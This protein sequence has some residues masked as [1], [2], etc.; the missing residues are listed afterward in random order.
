[1]KIITNFNK[2][3]GY[4]T[5]VS[6]QFIRA[7]GNDIDK[8][9][10]L[11]IIYLDRKRSFEDVV[12]FSLYDLVLS[13]GYKINRTN[14]GAVTSFKK[15]IQFLI[16]N[17]M[18]SLDKN[19]K[20]LK[21]NNF[22]NINILDNFDKVDNYTII[23]ANEIDSLLHSKSKIEKAN[24]F[25]VYLY[26]KSFM[27]PRNLTDEGNEFSDAKEKP[28]AFWGYIDVMQRDIG[29]SR[30]TINKC[31]KEYIKLKLFIRHETGSYIAI[32]NGKQV[33]KNAPNIYVLNNKNAEQEAKWALNKL[34]QQFNVKEFGDFKRRKVKA[35]D[36][37]P[38][39]GNIL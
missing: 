19:I 32:E 8:K 37:S 36:K 1:M 38:P 5:R 2:I 16:D 15:I 17:Q 25:S 33:E 18:I 12:G 9:I 4:F 30:E 24:L 23:T 13:N 21:G 29:V 14:T 20:E 27:F 39:S 7:N 34:K 31:L 22:V 6:N 10:L 35:K 26:M 11:T 28:I 3:K